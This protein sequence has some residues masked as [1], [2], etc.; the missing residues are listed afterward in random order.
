[1]RRFWTL[2]TGSGSEE[3]AAPSERDGG[4]ARVPME[5]SS[6]HTSVQVQR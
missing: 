4:V 1:M 2:P 5:N 6:M 3:E